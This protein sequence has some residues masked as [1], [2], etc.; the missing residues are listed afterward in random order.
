MLLSH[1]HKFIFLKTR[2]TASTST[3]IA[4]SRY[5]DGPD[6][7]ITPMG[8]EEES[9][10]GPLGIAPKNYLAA[11]SDYRAYDWFKLALR[12]RRKMRFW[13]HMTAQ[14]VQERVSP[15]VWNSYFKFTFD[16]NPWDK[17]VSNYFWRCTRD[18]RP[19]DLDEYFR[20]YAGNFPQYNY[21]YYSIG[22]EVAVDF[23]GRFEYL[24]ADM[25]YALQQV[26][27]KFDG[28]LPKAKS[29]T[30]SDRRHYSEIL[31]ARQRQVIADHFRKEIDL[32]GYQFEEKRAA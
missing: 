22:G 2:K 32:L 1:Q 17:T 5:C 12:G 10:R 7:V 28:W 27:I 26:G 4:L 29:H 15:E 3:E 21:Q 20:R 8:A 30:R 14:D 11:W 19:M 9:I 24:A 31:N 25:E 13:G 6:D 23:V 18:R 16:R